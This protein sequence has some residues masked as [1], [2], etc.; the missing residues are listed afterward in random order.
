MK[1]RSRVRDME[2]SMKIE[3]GERSEEGE[4]IWGEGRKE[5]RMTLRIR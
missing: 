3:K 4:I 5:K 2:K 1:T